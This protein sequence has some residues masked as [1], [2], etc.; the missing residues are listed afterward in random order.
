MSKNNENNNNS[1]TKLIDGAL[2]GLKIATWPNRQVDMAENNATDLLIQN[3]TQILNTTGNVAK[4][5]AKL[6][7]PLLLKAVDNSYMRNLQHSYALPLLKKILQQVTNINVEYIFS[8]LKKL[9][10]D[11]ES[12]DGTVLKILTVKNQKRVDVLAK[13]IVTVL[14]EYMTD[15]EKRKKLEELRDSLIEFIGES[16]KSLAVTLGETSGVLNE[17]LEEVKP[18]A[19]N[20][21]FSGIGTM[22]E[23][24]TAA[25]F[26]IP[27]IAPLQL[28]YKLL[29]AVT[30][31]IPKFLDLVDAIGNGA[32]SVGKLVSSRN[33]DLC[34]SMQPAIESQDKLRD[35]NKQINEIINNVQESD[36]V[37]TNTHMYDK[38]K[39]INEKNKKQQNK[40]QTSKPK[41]KQGLIDKIDDNFDI[42]GDL[43]GGGNS[44]ICKK[45]VQLTSDDTKK[46]N[47][48][49]NSFNL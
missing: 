18:V 20:F 14:E 40:N 13:I 7:Q 9:D 47:K 29:K 48:I 1:N 16:S 26:S 46:L 37:F 2:T 25:V 6:S 45:P 12:K 23:V 8:I 21:L 42:G 33:K 49:L 31:N 11:L 36:E 41:K 3:G 35:I 17:N 43:F 19:K 28:P 34:K 38:T 44:D 5:T 4:K 27:F 24:L 39:V 32:S 22:I 30:V 15:P 10:I